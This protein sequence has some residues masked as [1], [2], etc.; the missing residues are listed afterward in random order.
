[1]K[2]IN[3]ILISL[4]LIVLVISNIS[5]GT[6]VETFGN[7][8]D[9]NG[10]REINFEG[11]KYLG[12]IQGVGIILAVGVLMILG[13]KYM[14]GSVEERAEYKKSMIPYLVGAILLFAVTNIQTTIIDMANSI[15][16][17]AEIDSV[18][19]N[20]L[21]IIRV[22]G[23]IVAVG[24]VMVI[25]I[26]F[27]TGSAEERAEYKKTMLPYL[28]GAVLIF[29]TTNILDMM[30]TAITKEERPRVTYTYIGV[31]CLCGTYNKIN[32]TEYI[33]MAEMYR[34]HIGQSYA[35][36]YCEGGCRLILYK[37]YADGNYE[38]NDMISEYTIFDETIYY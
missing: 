4:V 35:Y 36:H 10:V 1:M 30:Y 25:G 34:D 9:A 13:I 32:H 37:C 8:I 3:I 15:M 33:E 38:I 28:I 12:V 29:A 26:K 17:N 23:I 27:M 5:Y 22:I 2:R 16:S 11:K 7:S 6:I 20:I 18:G 14:L 19:G 21:G 31:T 24:V